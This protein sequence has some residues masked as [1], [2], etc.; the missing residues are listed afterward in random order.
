M[1][2]FDFLPDELRHGNIHLPEIG[3]GVFPPTSASASLTSIPN[4]F[5]NQHSRRNLLGLCQNLNKMS[6]SDEER[7]IFTGSHPFLGS[8]TSKNLHGIRLGG[9]FL[10]ASSHRQALTQS[11]SG[12]VSDNSHRLRLLAREDYPKPLPNR[13]TENKDC[14]LE[15]QKRRHIIDFR[16]IRGNRIFQPLSGGSRKCMKE[17]EALS[18]SPDL[19]SVLGI[20]GSVYMAAKEQMGCRFLQKKL[21]EEGSFVDVMFIFRGLVNHLIELGVDQ[22][23]N[24]LV[25]K[26]I[27]VCDEQ[28]RTEIVIM[29]TSK[30]GL[31]VT[32]SLHNYGTRVV[33]KLIETVRTKTQINLVKAALKPGLLSLVTATNGNHVVLSCLKFLAPEDNKFVLEGATRFCATI[34]T[35]EHGCCVLQHCVQYSDGAERENLVAEIARNSL[36]LA[37]DPFG[38]Y[39]V[40][41][42]IEQNLGGVNVMF[43]L[44]GNYV[45]LAK[46]KFSSH[47]VEKCLIH[48]PESRSQI[49]HELVSDSN[50]ERLLQ[51]PFANYV[52]QSALSKTKGNVRARLMDKVRTFGNLSMNPYCKKIF[53]KHRRHL[54]K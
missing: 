35:H 24:F 11:S 51:D 1:D 52:I 5:V 37:Q 54:R 8:P 30:P 36:H 14:L 53:F 26:L 33:Q 3:F 19:V 48:Y 23:G 49:V 38:N 7:S 41:C 46:Q 16:E 50:F 28:Q 6:I 42:I 2:D 13:F 29:L 17:G 34:A 20:Y 18:L 10:E 31:L 12:E 27:Q 9:S 44:R 25:Q 43:E 21:M 40:Q 47:V 45:K 32:I 39:V 22:F 15:Q 4:P